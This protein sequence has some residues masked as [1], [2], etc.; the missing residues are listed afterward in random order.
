MEN[1][2]VFNG[3]ELTSIGRISTPSSTH[4]LHPRPVVVVLSPVSGLCVHIMINMYIYQ[5]TKL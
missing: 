1:E 4:S 5:T 3:G 2:T